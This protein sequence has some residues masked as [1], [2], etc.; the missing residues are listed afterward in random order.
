MHGPEI[1]KDAEILGEEAQQV[2]DMRPSPWFHEKV[3]DMQDMFQ[4]DGP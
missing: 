2:P 1:K 3:R 4:E